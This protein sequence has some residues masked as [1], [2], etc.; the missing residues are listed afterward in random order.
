MVWK[1]Q[2]RRSYIFFNWPC[3]FRDWKTKV[4][5]EEQ[6]CVWDEMD[7]RTI[8]FSSKIIFLSMF[9]AQRCVWA[10]FLEAQLWKMLMWVL[11]AQPRRK[12]SSV[13]R[14]TEL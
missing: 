3:S 7:I 6:V 1:V 11:E 2:Y 9:L 5:R 13:A 8:N 10:L 12:K 14:L 4:E